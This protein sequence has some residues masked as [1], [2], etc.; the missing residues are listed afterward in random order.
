MEENR[1]KVAL[2][3]ISP[4]W[5]NKIDTLKKVKQC[6]IDVSKEA[7]EL[8]VFGEGLVPGYPFWLALTGGAEW[9]KTVNKELH[10]HYVSNAICIEKDDLESICGLS[11][12]HK[13]AIYL[14]IIE[15]P[16][17]R[18]GHSIYASLVYINQE[19][20]IQSVHRKLQPTYD[21]RLTWSP[22]DGNGLQVHPLKKFTVGGLNCWENWMPLPRAALYGL[23]EDLHIAVWPGGD[24]NTKDI[25]RFI[26]R[27][28]R[29][30][31]ISASSLMAKGDFPKETPHLNQIIEKAPDILANGGSC[32]AGPDGEWIVEPV[33][34]KE[35]LIIQTIDFNRVLEERQN[36][37][38]VGHYSRPDVT[39]LS[40]NRTRQ[41]TVVFKD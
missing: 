23:G 2:A 10:A 38:P 9:D 11:K 33:L 16:L 7:V 36:F 35:G 5:L 40:V 39:K 18:G 1:L 27:E 37:D 26:A 6:I 4:V 22:G 30:F 3:Q 13:M 20:S 34:H 17:D 32:I 8:I 31:V 28:S 15:R 29:S 19:G 12:K 14:G 21:E 24:H 41:S 25:T